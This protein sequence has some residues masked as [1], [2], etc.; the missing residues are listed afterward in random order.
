MEAR[1]VARYVRISPRKARQVIDLIRGKDVG[2][3]LTILRHTPK[4]ASSVI[5]KTLRSAVANGTNVYVRFCPF[6]LLFGHSSNPPSQAALV[7]SA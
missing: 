1:A 6:K 7:S 5:E 4:A 2:E 3:A